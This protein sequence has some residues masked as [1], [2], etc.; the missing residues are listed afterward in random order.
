MDDNPNAVLQE[1]RDNSA[2]VSTLVT[3][4]KN[5]V[6]AQALAEGTHDEELKRVIKDLAEAKKRMGAYEAQEKLNAEMRDEY[7]ARLEELVRISGNTKEQEID[8]HRKAS[9]EFIATG[10]RSEFYDRPEIQQIS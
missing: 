7:E 5:K 9:V 3:E 10:V 6:D 8:E 4:I 1:L 2:Q